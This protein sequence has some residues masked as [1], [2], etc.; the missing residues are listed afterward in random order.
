M[1]YEGNIIRPPSEA[2]SIILQVTAGCSHNKCTFCGAYRDKKFRLRT[3]SF[4]AD[5]DF[6]SKYCRRQKRVFLADGDAL[7]IPQKQLVHLLLQIQKK[8]PWVNCISVYANCKAIRSKSA[9]D[10]LELKNLGL[11]RL[12]LGL[13]SGLDDVLTDVCKGETAHSM[14]DAATK[15]NSIGLF[16]SVTVLLGIAG[17][18]L[19]QRHAIATG[20]VLSKMIPRQIA[21]LTLMPLPNT[22]L[23][24]DIASGDFVL[25]DAT[26]LLHELKTLISNIDLDRVQFFSNHASNYLPL[27]GRLSRDK[28][29]F[30]KRIDSALGGSIPLVQENRRAL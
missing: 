27:S 25:P 7:I 19:S 23:F 4:E 9:E 16:L 6:A 18:D 5:L 21:A 24:H 13:E 12:Y 20:K 26:T 1:Q 3:D 30:L 8:L 29:S 22:E 2:N 11:D 17:V 14:I 28:N 10:L 15:V